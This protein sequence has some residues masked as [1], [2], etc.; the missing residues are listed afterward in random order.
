M[1]WGFFSLLKCLWSIFSVLGIVIDTE[2]SKNKIDM[3]CA[4]HRAYIM[5]R[6]NVYRALSVI[7]FQISM[8]EHTDKW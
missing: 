6:Q 4:P 1:K 7:V 3:A 2:Y 8:N 5:I